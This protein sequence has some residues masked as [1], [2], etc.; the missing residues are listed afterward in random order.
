M[1]RILLIISCLYSGVSFG[2]DWFLVATASDETRTYIN[3]ESFKYDPYNDSVTIWL[4]KDNFKT[5]LSKGY[6]VELKQLEN[7]SCEAKTV[8]N[9]SSVAYDAK[10]DVLE[11]INTNSE[12]SHIIPDTVGEAVMNYLCKNPKYGL[13]PE[14]HNYDSLDD[15]VKAVRKFTNIDKIQIDE[16]K[17]GKEPALMDFTSIDDYTNALRKYRELYEKSEKRV[18]Q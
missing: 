6:A 17:Y 8:R 13:Q 18:V 5:L 16:K 11:T 2:A 4:K 9:I 3:R 7:Y 12:I 14:I 15:Y 10:G 1:R